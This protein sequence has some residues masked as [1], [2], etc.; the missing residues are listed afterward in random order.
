MQYARRMPVLVHEYIGR[1]CGISRLMAA[2]AQPPFFGLNPFV[3]ATSQKGIRFVRFRRKNHVC[4]AE[5]KSHV[6][7]KG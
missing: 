7:F 3:C 4:H 6:A 1:I 5:Q 2:H